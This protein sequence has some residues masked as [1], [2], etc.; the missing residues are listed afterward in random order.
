VSANGDKPAPVT[1]E[2]FDRRFGQGDVLRSSSTAWRFAVCSAS[3][4]RDLVG[5]NW[6]DGTQG[7]SAWRR[8]SSPSAST[9]RQGPNWVLLRRPGRQRA[10]ALHATW[11]YTRVLQSTVS[12]TRSSVRTTESYSAE[13]WSGF[14]PGFE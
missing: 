14:Q 12:Q 1:D 7:L 6:L 13:F 10:S 3:I 8:F 5:V 9:G 4:M 11:F 2:R